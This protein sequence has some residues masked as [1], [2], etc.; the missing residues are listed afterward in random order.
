MPRVA[1]R[2]LDVS[3]LVSEKLREACCLYA[4]RLAIHR[5]R[6]I[7]VFNIAILTL[8]FPRPFIIQ[9]DVLRSQDDP[10]KFFFYEVYVSNAHTISVCDGIV[11]LQ[12][13]EDIF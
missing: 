9:I 6:V 5:G 4:C 7:H 10:N 2:S 13:Y 3:A 12:M 8:C 11:S 1:A